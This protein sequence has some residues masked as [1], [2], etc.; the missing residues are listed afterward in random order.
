MR[1]PWYPQWKISAQVEYGNYCI[2]SVGGDIQ[3]RRQKTNHR[4]YCVSLK[5]EFL[6]RQLTYQGKTP[7]C[8][9][10]HVK[11]PDGFHVIQPEKHWSNE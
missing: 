7:A 4:T 11:F 5:E 1:G 2:P 9:P 3:Y 8:H 10:K 6:P